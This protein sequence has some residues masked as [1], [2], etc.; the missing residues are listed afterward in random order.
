MRTTTT[1]ERACD[2]AEEEVEADGRLSHVRKRSV[3]PLAGHG[4][5]PTPLRRRVGRPQLKRDPLGGALPPHRHSR[6]E[7]RRVGK[8]KIKK[9]FAA[10]YKLPPADQ[11]ALGATI[12]EEVKIEGL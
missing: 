6:S 12:L 1:C 10:A 9:A 8:E 4:L 3:V 11:D 7:E 5:R 2:A